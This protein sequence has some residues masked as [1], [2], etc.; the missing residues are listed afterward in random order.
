MQC[1]AAERGPFRREVR[2]H[3]VSPLNIGAMMNDI[4]KYEFD[5]L[6]YLVIKAMLTPTEVATLAGAIDE[7]EEHLSTRIN[8]FE[9]NEK[10][11]F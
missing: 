10:D 11:E 1:S 8:I 6:G 5:R 7:L 9:S 3:C 4:E 2:E